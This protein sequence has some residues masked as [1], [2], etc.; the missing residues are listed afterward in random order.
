M[1]LGHT[2][3]GSMRQNVALTN[4]PLTLSVSL[5]MTSPL[6]ARPRDDMR[7]IKGSFVGVLPRYLVY[8]R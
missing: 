7:P 5:V 4:P 3:D 1:V 6:D 2:R 8:S